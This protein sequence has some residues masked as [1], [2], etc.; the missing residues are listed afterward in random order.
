MSAKTNQIENENENENKNKKKKNI[1]FIINNQIQL[2]D[3]N[4]FQFQ[5]NFMHLNEKNDE[6]D[7]TNSANKKNKKDSMNNNNQQQLLHEFDD[8][9]N[10]DENENDVQAA[11]DF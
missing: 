1:V 6:K 8:L 3:E 2:I 4:V 7:L 5:K 9:K 11:L 10:F